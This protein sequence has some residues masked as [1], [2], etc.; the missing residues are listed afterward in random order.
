[1]SHVKPFD[2]DAEDDPKPK[3]KEDRPRPRP[4]PAE[5]PAEPPPEP[6]VS[7]AATF[8]FLK[9][10]SFALGCILVVAAL[11]QAAPWAAALAGMACF[12][13]IAARL[14]QAEELHYRK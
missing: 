5:R 12:C 6:P 14:A 3:Q 8:G 11:N 13:G 10:G 9:W 2:F 7:P 1:M 4:R